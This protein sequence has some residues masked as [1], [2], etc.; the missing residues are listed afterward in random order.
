MSTGVIVDADSHVMDPDDTGL[1]AVAS[2][3]GPD[4][5]MW[6]SDWPHPEGHTNPLK[7]VKQNITGLPEEDQNKIL[8]ENALNMYGLALPAAA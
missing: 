8:G 5:F 2:L 1:G 6:G 3:V 7:K 4:R